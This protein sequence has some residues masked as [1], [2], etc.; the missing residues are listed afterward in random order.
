LE[1][2][3]GDPSRWL[4]VLV[5]PVTT[6]MITLKG[7]N[8]PEDNPE[9]DAAQQLAGGGANPG[10]NAMA[11]QE[12]GAV[13]NPAGYPLP[14][15]PPPRFA[16][17]LTPGQA[18]IGPIDFYGKEGQKYYE[19][20]TR[21]LEKEQFK[22]VPDELYQFIAMLKMRSVEFGWDNDQTGVLMIP[23]NY[24]SRTGPMTNI[25]EEYGIMNLEKLR[26]FE[27]TYMATATRLAQDD[28][29]LFQC[30]YNSISKEGKKKILIWKNDYE[31]KIGGKLY[32]SGILLLKVV[33]RESHL[34]TNATISMVHH[35][36][37]NL[38]MYMSTIR[39]DVTKF[40]GYVKM[41]VDGLSARGEIRTTCS[42]TCL[43]D[44][45]LVRISHSWIISAENKKNM[46]KAKTSRLRN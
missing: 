35:K 14:P 15:A 40:N 10:A 18:F 22:C 32:Q 39:N 43:R 2:I 38:D 29:L 7:E 31:L 27:E 26:D 23:N 4:L 45:A 41:L 17:A 1:G 8:P 21:S 16:F 34:G 5:V 36:L 42:L 46:T 25:L 13:A 6:L 9:P 28:R 44:T 30:I 20:G 33:I 37:S 19:N 12:A 24:S 3:G 11:N